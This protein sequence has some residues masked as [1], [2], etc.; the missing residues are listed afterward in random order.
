MSGGAPSL[1]FWFYIAVVILV[2]TKPKR[3]L[4]REVPQRSFWFYVLQPIEALG[5]TENFLKGA[6]SAPFKKFSVF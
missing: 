3:A 4:R 6:R 5:S 2:R 1:I